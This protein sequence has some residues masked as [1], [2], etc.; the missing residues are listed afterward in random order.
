MSIVIAVDMSGNGAD[1]RTRER[2]CPMTK[3]KSKSNAAADKLRRKRS[4]AIKSVA[5]ASAALDAH[6]KC[7]NAPGFLARFDD[8]SFPGAFLGAMTVHEELEYQLAIEL[9][10][11]CYLDEQAAEYSSVEIIERTDSRWAA[12]EKAIKGKAA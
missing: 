10:N 1:P 12:G 7:W 4:A 2:K 5:V 3:H 9:N 11:L 8:E 6:L